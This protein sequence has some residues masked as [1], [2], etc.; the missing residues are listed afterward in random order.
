MSEQRNGQLVLKEHSILA[1]RKE[2]SGD[3]AAGQHQGCG[4]VPHG[5]PLSLP[6]GSSLARVSP[7][8]RWCGDR[9]GQQASVPGRR[10]QGIFL[11]F[12]AWFHMTARQGPTWAGGAARG[13][14]GLA[15]G[16][17]ACHKGQGCISVPLPFLG[18]RLAP[19]THVLKPCMTF[20]PGTSL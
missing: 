15:P 10:E 19:P 9:G 7:R 2:G 4:L 6:T 18:V 1:G 5:Q 14:P 3:A 11:N 13:R 12:P 8:G 16:G 20:D 17:E